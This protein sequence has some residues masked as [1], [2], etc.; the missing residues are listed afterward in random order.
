[1]Y[2]PTT[3]IEDHAR[4]SGSIAVNGN[5]YLNK[6]MRVIASDPKAPYLSNCDGTCVHTS[7]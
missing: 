4:G 3:L 5:Y 2:L 6:S 7:Q 1:M